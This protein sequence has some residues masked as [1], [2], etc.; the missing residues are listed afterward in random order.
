ML[1]KFGPGIWL[2]DGPAVTAAAGFHYPTRMAV[3]KLSGGDLFIWSPVA[4]TDQLRQDIHA[5][6]P[7]R[8]L[9]A[10]NSLHHVFL[11]EWSR[12]FPDAIIYAP[13]GLREKRPDINFH[14]DL[15]DAP[16]RAW[17]E[18]IDQVMMK[19]NAITT[20]IVFFH[21]PSGTVLFTDLL[22][23]LPKGWYSG[24]RALVA[25]LDLMLEAEPAVP[26]KF[27][28]AFRDK[29]A[30]RRSIARVQAWPAQAVVMAHGAPV[31]E[32]AA[33]YLHRAFH[34]LTKHKA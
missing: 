26:R 33:D 1:T 24:W 29:A 17:A 16:D 25:R 32:N 4:L 14:R 27:R 23:H 34:W 11:E 12:A 15:A 19:G 6:G 3:M 7:V 9:I 2:A 10:P 18:D 30:A 5:L 31:I 8:H 22:Q 28:L 13:P 20:E 21:R